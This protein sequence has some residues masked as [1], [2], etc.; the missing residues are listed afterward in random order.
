MAKTL[1]QQKILPLLI[2]GVL[3]GIASASFAQPTEQTQSASTGKKVWITVGEKAFAQLQRLAPQTIAKESALLGASDKTTTNERSASNGGQER[4]HLV[5]VDE[6]MLNGLSG[7]IH[8]ELHRCGGFMF[9]PSEAAGRKALAPQ[10]ASLAAVRPS[11]VIANQTTV[12]AMLPLMQASNIGQ[13][14]LDMSSAYANRY[15]T[16]N[17]GVNSSNWLMQRW[18]KMIG[19]RTDITV[20]QFTHANWPQKSVILTIKGSD[21]G[22]EVVVL[23]GHLDSI[24]SAGTTETTIAPGADDDASGIASMTE[25]LRVMVANNYKPRRSIK[26]IGYAAEEVG[27]RGSQDIATNFK[28]NNVNVVGVMQLDMTNYK[29]STGDIYLY[30]DYT[31]ASQNTFIRNLL[32]TY[33]PTVVVGTDKC[34]YACSDHASWTAQ[35]YFASM[36]FETLMSQDNPKIHTSGDTY[37]NTGSQA[38]QALKFSKMALAYA[39]ELGSAGPVAPPPADK[40][41]TFTGSLLKSATKSYGPFKVGAGGSFKAALT[42]TG[43]IDLY[44]R[45]SALPTTTTNDC[46]SAGAT[47]TESCT[48]SMT[49]N[50]DVYVLLSGYAAGSYTLKA[51]YRPQ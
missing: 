27:L 30:S 3:F 34:G 45:K 10:S 12:N 5:E 15:Y 42:G 2:A 46:K 1:Q 49:A 43:D 6:S 38:V 35:G 51:T 26:F 8:D 28:T 40:V 39:V 25:V 48:I 23:G 14:I 24:N 7:A 4:V 41:E 19:T 47:S 37:A 13:T 17:A 32:S 9:H 29:G 21:N 18:Q 20:S 33:L 22:S 44:V 36:P 50:G 31:D 11:Y 16:T